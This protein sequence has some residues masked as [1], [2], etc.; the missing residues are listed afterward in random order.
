MRRF[1]LALGLI[2]VTPLGGCTHFG[3]GCGG[4]TGHQHASSP[5][6]ASAPA[7]I[8]SCPMH[9]TVTATFPSRCPECGMALVRK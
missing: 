5:A 8:Y 9:P 3:G 6:P 2:A 1:P 7:S 4:S